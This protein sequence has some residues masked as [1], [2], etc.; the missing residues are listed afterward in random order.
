MPAT[1]DD[2]VAAAEAIEPKGGLTP[3]RLVSIG[4]SAG[5]HLA[6]YL[7]SRVPLDGVVSQAGVL[8]LALGAELGLS[9]GVVDEFL[10][11]APLADA[12]PVERLP[13]RARDALDPR[14]PRRHRPAGDQ[15]ALR[16]GGTRG[17]RRRR[18]RGRPGGRPL[19]APRSGA[20][21]VAGGDGVAGLTRA[22][23]E[24]ADAA[25]PLAAFRDRFVHADD[26]I[27]LDG[28]SLGR[29]PIA[30]RD[31]LA[32]LAAEWGEQ[33]VSRLAALDRRAG[34]GGRR[35]RRGDR[36]AAGRGDR[37]RLDDGEPVQARRRA[38]IAAQAPRALVI[39]R[40]EFPTDR[41]VRRGPRRAAR[42]WQR[43]RREPAVRARRPRRPLP[44]QLPHRRAA[45]PRRRCRPRPTPRARRVIWDLS[46]SAGA[47]PVDLHDAGARVR[48]RL[49]LQV[50]Q[51]RPGGARLPLR[52]RGPPGRAAL[53]HPG[54][55][56]PGRPV[57]DGARLRAAR[58]HPPLPRRHAA[59]PRPRR[60]GGGR[61]AHRR[62]RRR[63]RCTRRRSR[64]RS[65]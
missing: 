42:T 19:R 44:R 5:G 65:G 32:A 18:P 50:P 23:A 38:S 46:H 43:S 6:A 54:L 52:A 22:D 48:G 17:G 16:G 57:R 34:H 61:E 39:D 30:T 36:R 62:G 58:R 1:L 33:L 4:H 27:Y 2:V 24:A 53:A 20:P 60:G 21:A 9:D 40:D 8:D 59:D 3:F 47:V 25:D 49:H 29:L 63:R 7:A 13:L 10:G 55:V 45:R 12:S 56:R 37:L 15:R 28:N 26:R 41:Y 11:G 51:R 31:R 64:S 35:D 14:R